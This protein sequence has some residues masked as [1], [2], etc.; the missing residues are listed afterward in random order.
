LLSITISGRGIH[1]SL[2]STEDAGEGIGGE[3]FG[4][5]GIDGGEVVGGAADGGI[6]AVLRSVEG[7]GDEPPEQGG[8]R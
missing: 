2:Y 3:E 4:V 7:A 8:M 1:P 5:D 6:D